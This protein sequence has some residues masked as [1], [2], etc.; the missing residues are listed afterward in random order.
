MGLLGLYPLGVKPVP[1]RSG[2]RI[3]RER[4]ELERSLDR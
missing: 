1:V 2:K 3:D 4:I